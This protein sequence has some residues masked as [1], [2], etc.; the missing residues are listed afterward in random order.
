MPYSSYLLAHL[1]LTAAI[2]MEMSEFKSVLEMKVVV[3]QHC[4]LR[5]RSYLSSKIGS[6]L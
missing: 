5:F 1:I 2:P 4:T 6:I 3:H